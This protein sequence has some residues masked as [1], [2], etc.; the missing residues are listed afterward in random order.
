MYRKIL[1][2]LAV[3]A[4]LGTACTDRP[5]GNPVAPR[6]TASVRGTDLA[7]ALA[8]AARDPGFSLSLRDALRVSPYDGHAL[9][10]SDFL[11]GAGREAVLSAVARELNLR[12]DSVRALAESW[13][14][15]AIAIERRAD[16]LAWRGTPGVTVAAWFENEPIPD[17]ATASFGAHPR[18]AQIDHGGEAAMTYPLVTVSPARYWIVRAFPQAAGPG[19]VIQDP[20]DGEGGAIDITY[21]ESGSVVVTQLAP[22]I[23]ATTRARLRAHKGGSGPSPHLTYPGRVFL[24]GYVA[25]SIADNCPSFC[26]N[27]LEMEWHTKWINIATGAV[28]M[29]RVRT[30][31]NI[32][33]THGQPLGE[34]YELLPVVPDAYNKVMVFVREDDGTWNPSDNFGDITLLNSNGSNGVNDLWQYP[35]FGGS[36]GGGGCGMAVPGTGVVYSCGGYHPTLATNIAV[37]PELQY[38]FQWEVPPSPPIVA[39][40]TGPSDIS[41]NHSYTW[42]VSNLVSIT[43]ATSYSW[44]VDGV[45]VGTGSSYYG[46][47]AQPASVHVLRVDVTDENG[48]WET[49]EMMI[50]VNSGSCDPN[51][52]NCFESLRATAPP[53]GRALPD[54]GVARPR[55]GGVRGR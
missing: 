41:P 21:L 22:M 25:I 35:R 13:A 54:R 46:A 44:S 34:T 6:S 49:A 7:R 8:R 37:W 36:H 55:T 43:G 33:G 52:P 31:M 53:T 18:L 2:A 23:E 45:V 39:S 50:N 17:A 4:L 5:D 26:D 1:Y 20:D 48:N 40:V 42:T 12:P 11:L 3:V 19:D 38:G 27:Q 15:L 24:K 16:R 51:D 28:R 32:F 14:H 10:L 9:R 47:I 29:S 30:D